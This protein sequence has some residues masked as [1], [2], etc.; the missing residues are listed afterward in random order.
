[1]KRSRDR[2]T[3]ARKLR[4]ERETIR[5]LHDVRLSQAPGADAQPV[6][7]SLSP[8]LSHGNGYHC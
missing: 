5:V 2:Q 4:L 3:P 1:M 7:P 6:E 8:I